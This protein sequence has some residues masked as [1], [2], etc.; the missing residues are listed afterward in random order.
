LLQQFP[1]LPA[2]SILSVIFFPPSS[3]TLPVPQ[4]VRSVLT[5]LHQM[6]RPHVLAVGRLASLIHSVKNGDEQGLL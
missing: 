3:S 5:A 4:S 6:S 2:E 1:L